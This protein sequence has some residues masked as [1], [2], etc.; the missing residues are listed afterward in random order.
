MKLVRVKDLF[1]VKYGVNL[2]LNKLE[3]VPLDDANAIPYVARSEKNNGVTA[4]QN[5]C[6]CIIALHCL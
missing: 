3:E 2:D 1:D 4:Y 5:R 6:C